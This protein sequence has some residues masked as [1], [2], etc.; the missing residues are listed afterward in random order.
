MYVEWCERDVC[1]PHEYLLDILFLAGFMVKNLD[2]RETTNVKD[3]EKQQPNVL[4]LSY[5]ISWK[6]QKIILGN[7]F[8][9]YRF[10]FSTLNTK[11]CLKIWEM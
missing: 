1:F 11:V 10:T 5:C 4:I 6:E 9:C 8:F 3:A 2:T 7:V